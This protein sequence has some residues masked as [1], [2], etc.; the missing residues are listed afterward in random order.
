MNKFLGILAS[1]ILSINAF[2]Y[3]WEDLK[4][5]TM[6]A[7]SLQAKLKDAFAAYYPLEISNNP[8]VLVSGG[9]GIKNEN[10]EMV[11]SCRDRSHS[12]M[13]VQMHFCDVGE[14]DNSALQSLMQV[15]SHS[16]DSTSVGHNHGYR[17]RAQDT[18]LRCLYSARSTIV[19]CDFLKGTYKG[20]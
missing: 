19:R 18:D 8:V 13:A 1:T 11:L 6:S 14:M 20:Y 15:L 5:P 4:T 10:G 3:S 2:A 9:F 12:I 16:G 17:L 7:W